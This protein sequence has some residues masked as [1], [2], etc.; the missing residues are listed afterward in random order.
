MDTH[1]AIYIITDTLGSSSNA[2]A[3]RT[4]IVPLLHKCCMDLYFAIPT[5]GRAC[6]TQRLEGAAEVL[7]DGGR[8]REL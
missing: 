8:L 4:T 2:C 5:T 1:R 3:S 6:L 7:E